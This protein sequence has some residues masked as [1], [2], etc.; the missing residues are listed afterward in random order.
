MYYRKAPVVAGAFAYLPLGTLDWPARCC[1][2][3]YP[4]AAAGR[5]YLV[6]PDL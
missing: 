3:A 5:A 2:R 1:H 4:G 6:M